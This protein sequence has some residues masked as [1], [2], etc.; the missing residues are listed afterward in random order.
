MPDTGIVLQG[1][2]GTADGFHHLADTIGAQ[3]DAASLAQARRIAATAARLAP[4]QSGRLARSVDTAATATGA[5]VTFGGPSC[6][7]AGVIHYG[8]HKD[9]R[10]GRR[11]NIRPHPFLADAIDQETPAVLAAWAGAV[12]DALDTQEWRD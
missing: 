4:H 2:D 7:Y 8:A 11:R 3:L 1:A 12:Q 5:E 6:V 10:T 9:V